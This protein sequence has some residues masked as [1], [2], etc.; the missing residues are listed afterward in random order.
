MNNYDFINYVP[1]NNLDYMKN[2]NYTNDPGM[3]MF[4]NNPGSSMGG[5]TNYSLDILEPYEGFMRGNLFKSLYDPYKNYKYDE[6]EAK[7]ERQSL[8]NQLLM[9]KFAAIDLGLYLDV[10][11]NDSTAVRMFNE[12]QKMEKQLSKQYEN[13]YG[14]LTLDSDSLNNR[15]WTW[16]DSPWPWEEI[17]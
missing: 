14:P 9:Y 7:N 4:M 16:I 8:L 10:N 13:T 17:K 1:G 2:M 11:P 12:Y 15:T 3:M 6:V 5:S